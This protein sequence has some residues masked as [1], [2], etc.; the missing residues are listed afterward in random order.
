MPSSGLSDMK[1]ISA[2]D[3]RMIENIEAMFGPEPSELG[4]VKNLFWG[5][6]QENQVFP[7]P[8]ESDD[9]RA[10]CDW[11][12]GEL[13]DYLRNEHPSAKIDQEEAIPQWCLD[14]L[15]EMGVMGM[16][17]PEKYD[18]LG[19]GVTSYNRVLELIGRHCSSTAVV[20]SAHQSIGCKAI[21]LFGTEAQKDE[22]LPMVARE[23]L[24]AFCLSEPNAG[25]D[26]AGQQTTC[27]ESEDGEHFI[28]NG[29]KKWST[30]GALSGVFT[31]MCKNMVW[32]AETGELEQQGV[33]ALICTPDMEGVDIFEKNR[34]KTGIRGTWQAR[35][36]FD[37]VK[38]PKE[39]LLHERGNGLKV[40]L[41]CLNYGR[42]TL[43][44][45]VGGAAKFAFE[46][47]TKWVQTRHQFGRPLADFELV[48]QRIARMGA[49]CYAI[50]A[51][52]YM[53]TGMMDRGDEDIMVETAITKLFC[54]RYGWR[55]I[56]D[57]MQIMGG[58]GYVTENEFERVW[59]DNRIHR[60]VEGSNEV[61]QSFI[62][63][64]GGKQLAEQ[65]VSV[66]EALAWDEER[67]VGENLR[68]L[69]RNG[70]NMS[71][72]RRAVPLG[73]E[74]F[75][76]YRQSAPKIRGLHPDLRQFGGRLAR[77]VSK[78]ARH[79]KLVS[80][81]EREE[82]VT[83]QAQQARVADNAVLLFALAASLSKMDKQLREGESGP[84]FERD[85]AAFRHL[86]DLFETE[87]SENT[88]RMRR[89]NDDTM[90]EAAE[91]AR[92]HNDT[93]PNGDYAIHEASPTAAGT[94]RSLPLE[95]IKQFPGDGHAPKQA[96]GGDGVAAGEEADLRAAKE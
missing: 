36:R 3:R 77:L 76:G 81:W 8:E 95:A 65:M 29:E 68:R 12:L 37:D 51:V 46:Q 53:M 47:G 4:F 54:S 42:C 62:F 22:F 13:E 39:R 64:Y 41:T 87:F 52:L 92:A 83:R 38:V 45:S 25:S 48:Q 67:P 49:Y 69:F 44:A 34:S 14:R 1:G 57:V 17:V 32:D 21:M 18:G 82:I 7:Y 15:F 88:S 85:K 43:S 66:Q 89:H 28:L 61:M 58:E 71:L 2:E 86:F 31:V 19:L 90:R 84:A 56:D 40:A 75:L 70:T 59:R 72:L 20:V 6:F 73:A 74:L 50:D 94:G 63:A 33:N 24:S 35:L 11:L 91:A 80:K 23:E 10:R 16:T 27:R 96:A 78:H 60:I 79:F 93:L 26:A 9:E 55:V 30:S 5:R